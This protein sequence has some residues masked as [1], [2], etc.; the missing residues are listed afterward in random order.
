MMKAREVWDAQEESRLYKMSAMK[1]VLAQIEGKVRQ[2]AI[3]NVNA[4]YILFE[5]PS[6]VFGYPLF[7]YKDAVDYIM[8]E[9]LKAGFWVWNVDEKYLLISWLKPVKTRD[10]GKPMLVTNYRPQAYDGAFLR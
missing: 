5:V 9:L 6:F 1:P 2:Q 8:N 7:N 3:A 10:L 4:P